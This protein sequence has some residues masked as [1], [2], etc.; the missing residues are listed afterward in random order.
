[1]DIKG[2]LRKNQYT[3]QM[4]KIF[5]FIQLKIENSLFCI[6]GFFRR[7]GIDKRYD[8]IENLKGKYDGERCF[9]IA[10][11]P[12]LTSEDILKVKNEYTFTMNA[13]CL[14]FNELQWK[15][16]FYG[17]QDEKVFHRL[18]ND[19]LRANIK[20]TFVDGAYRKEIDNGDTWIY[21]PRNYFYNA[22]A[23]HFKHIYKAKFSIDCKECVYEGF[24]IT[25]SLIQIAVYLGFKEIYLMGC[26][27][28]YDVD[29]SKSY[30]V[31]HG[32]VD[33]TFKEAGNRMT[34]AYYRAKEF[35][36]KNNVKI[37]NAT[38]GGKLE[39]FERVNLDDIVNY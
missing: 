7:I 11:G 27:C 26:D 39:V 24:T 32:I 34:A 25:Y 15:P 38:R 21:F 13:M 12:S 14:K 23:A 37:F 31:D 28:S 1:M 18:K 30:F 3:Y 20:Y 16:T 4:G 10:T 22:Y 6:G 2:I 17:I 8:E 5:R 19:I 29:R 33:P 9:I 35:A 36:D